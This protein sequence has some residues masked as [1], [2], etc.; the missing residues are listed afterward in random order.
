MWHITGNICVQKGQFNMNGINWQ[1]KPYHHCQ[2]ANG[3]NGKIGFARQKEI[4]FFVYTTH[5]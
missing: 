5:L 4:N 2:N 3:S 1:S